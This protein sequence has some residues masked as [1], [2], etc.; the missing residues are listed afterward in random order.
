MILPAIAAG[1]GVA[2]IVMS[3]NPFIVRAQDAAPEAAQSAPQP[4]AEPA[5]PPDPAAELA[6]KRDQT[7]AEL[8]TLSKTINLSTDKVSALQQSIADLEKSTESIRQALIDSAARRKALEKQILESEKKLADLGVKEDGIRRSLHERRGL[9]AEVLA[10]LQRMGRNPPP[11]LLVTPDDALASVRSAILLGAVV[12]G[13]R[14]ETDKLAADLASLAALQTASAAEKT[15]LTG[16]MT[17]GIEEERRMDLL[18]AENDKLSRSNAA[19]LG[20]ERKRSEELAGKA[21]S[22]EGLVASMESE[23]ASVRDAAAAARQ[24]EEN[25]KLLTDEQ[26]AQAKALADSGV[27]DKNRIAPAYPFGELKAKL[28]VPVT[29]DI[30]RQFGDADGTGHEAMG[31]TVATN[32]ETVVTAP[33]DGLVVFAGVFRSYGQMIILDAGDGYHLVLSGMD[34]INTRQ[35]KFV[36]SGEPLA[37]MGAK[38]VASATALALETNR[39]TL[40]IEFRKDGKPVDSRPWWT[41]KD[42]GKAR[43][44]S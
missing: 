24:A 36:F 39:P 35:G 7:R 40:Y 13:I 33:A 15:S 20:A 23:I 25:R 42:T 38:R 16:T 18:L 30:L 37:V 4:A 19:E 31:M 12:P 14:K 17:D 6:A 26:R 8:E 27:P 2:V 34:T 1:V 10:A 5:P 29:G 28:E 21:T 9:L 44:D 41:A 22:L 43:N 3:A 11:A 32:P